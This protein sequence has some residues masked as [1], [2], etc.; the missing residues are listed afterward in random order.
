MD[1]D[2]RYCLQI[3]KLDG[4]I[5]D[6]NGNVDTQPGPGWPVIRNEPIRLYNSEWAQI[7]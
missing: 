4:K 3:Y 2:F 6:T 1:Q 7:N 5:R